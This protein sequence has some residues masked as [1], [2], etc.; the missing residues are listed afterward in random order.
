MVENINMQGKPF[1]VTLMDLEENKCALIMADKGLS[2]TMVM[3]LDADQ[4]SIQGLPV[5]GL[6]QTEIRIG[7][8][9]D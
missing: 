3:L 6:P 2:K 4:I 8:G 5:R 7:R 1:T 9:Q